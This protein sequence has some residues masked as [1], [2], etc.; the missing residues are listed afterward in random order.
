MET[1]KLTHEQINEVDV[2][3]IVTRKKKS[4]VGQSAVLDSLAR[5]SLSEEMT[6]SGI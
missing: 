5:E 6:Q 3:T 4:T 2:V 1:L